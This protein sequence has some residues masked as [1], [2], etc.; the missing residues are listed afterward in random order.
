MARDAERAAGFARNTRVAVRSVRARRNSPLRLTPP[1]P[2]PPRLAVSLAP[3]TWYPDPANARPLLGF[4]SANDISFTGEGGGSTLNATLW[5]ATVP[6]A[7]LRCPFTTSTL[8]PCKTT[9]PSFTFANKRLTMVVPAGSRADTA[10]FT[11][12]MV[13]RD[14]MNGIG[15]VE[16]QTPTGEKLYLPTNEATVSVLRIV[17]HRATSGSAGF[18]YGLSGMIFYDIDPVKQRPRWV[19]KHGVYSYGYWSGSSSSSYGVFALYE[20]NYCWRFTATSCYNYRY[21]FSVGAAPTPTAPW[22]MITTRDPIAQNWK[23]AFAVNGG[24][25]RNY[26]SALADSVVLGLTGFIGSPSYGNYLNKVDKTRLQVAVY[27][28]HLQNTGPIASVTFSAFTLWKASDY[29][30]Q[31]YAARKAAIDAAEAVAQTKCGQHNALT[32]VVDR[33]TSCG[34]ATGTSCTAKLAGLMNGFN[35]TATVTGLKSSVAGT[36]TAVPGSVRTLPALPVPGAQLFLDSKSLPTWAGSV[37]AAPVN[38]AL[39][40][41]DVS[42]NNYVFSNAASTVNQAP[43]SDEPSL[44]D[45]FSRTLLQYLTTRDTNRAAPRPSPP[46]SS[47]ELQ[48]LVRRAAVAGHDVQRQRRPVHAGRAHV[49]PRGGL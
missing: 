5:N 43:V 28:D 7:F 39:W 40:W 42:G 25:V 19:L 47:A 24:A 15:F 3:V 35:Y 37:G 20:Y 21:T 36:T 33:V 46:P 26:G 45:V 34:S 16:A 8:A 9:T 22:D 29:I 32:V 14:M 41:Q 6:G 11:S 44:R 13:A 1:S 2:Q 18:Y 17:D 12:N 10:F 49:L 48:G 38:Q 31:A 30:A 23:F 4:T 27:A